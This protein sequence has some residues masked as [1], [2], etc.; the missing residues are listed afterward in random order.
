MPASGLQT[1]ANKSNNTPLAV[2]P[3]LPH[4]SLRGSAPPL[5]HICCVRTLHMPLRSDHAM[6]SSREAKLDGRASITPTM[7]GSAAVSGCVWC[8]GGRI[9]GFGLNCPV[10][11]LHGCDALATMQPHAS[12]HPHACVWMHMPTLTKRCSLH[13]INDHDTLEARNASMC[14]RPHRQ[15]STHA[16]PH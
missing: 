14:C 15:R 11:C 5:S 7:Y 10:Q 13:N 2:L 6:A 8:E 12:Q 9:F 16:M 1:T 3:P 4:S